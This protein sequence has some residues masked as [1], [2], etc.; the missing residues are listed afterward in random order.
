MSVEKH[1]L[2]AGTPY[3]TPYY[4]ISSGIPGP[5]FMIISGVHGNEPASSRAAQGIA[6]RFSRGDMA[7]R[8]GR[9]IIVPL[10]NQNARR[11]GVRGKPDLNRTFPR[12]PGAEAK[13]PLSAAVWQLAL[14]YKPSWALDLH[15]ANGLSQLNPKRV[16]QSLLI[17][18]ASRAE[19]VA[20]Q[21]VKRMNLNIPKQA[22]RFNMRYRERAGTS[23]MAFQRLLGARAVTVETCWSLDYALRVRLQ[24]EIVC[25]FLRAAG[26]I[27]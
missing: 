20:K 24:S 7:L 1:M 14:R 6:S 23:R 5:V 18:P 16:G 11:K 13:H 19:G 15:E 26:M 25:H 3:A 8:A 9:L 4:V 12:R 22:Y 2:A 27:S 10:V 17:S 21:I